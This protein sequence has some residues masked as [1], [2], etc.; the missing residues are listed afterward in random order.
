M[1]EFSRIGERYDEKKVPKGIPREVNEREAVFENIDVR[2]KLLL[3]L[4]AGT[5]RFSLDAIEK[6]ACQAIGL[7][8]I[9]E[10]LERGIE[11]ATSLRVKDRISAVIADVRY[12]P[13]PRNAFDLVIAVE[14]FEHLPTGRK[15]FI[16]EVYRV[17]K[18]SGTA[19]ISAWNAIPR[20]LMGLLL[21]R[22]RKLEWKDH[23]YYRYDYPCEF[24]RFIL[25][26][27]FRNIRILGA[28]NAYFLPSLERMT[29]A[30]L[31]NVSM[32]S[33][34]V[35]SLEITADKLFR[36]LAPFNLMTGLYLLAIV[37]K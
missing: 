9:R 19:A 20:K 1:I 6:G 30:N 36:K 4:G 12:L 37:R 5:L 18:K 3:D 7:D 32:L 31:S 17:L 28:H 13:F 33:K 35:L 8:N 14:L 24:K 21:L 2:N 34:A 23:F 22:K 10:M 29:L 11:K 25:S 26:A 16:M 27:K 15:R